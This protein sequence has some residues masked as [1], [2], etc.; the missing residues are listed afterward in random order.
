MI[1]ILEILIVG[2]VLS[3]DSFSAALAMGARKHKKSDVLKF[4]FSSG[5]AE[6]LVTFLGSIAGAKVIAEFDSVDHWISFFLLSIVAIHMAIE[7]VAE[8]KSHKKNDDEPKRFH[9]FIK[10]LIV[11]LAT[12]LDAFAVGVS[13]GVAGKPLVPFIFS[14]GLWAFFSTIIGMKVASKAS[15]KLGP[16]FSLIGSLVIITLAFKFLFEGL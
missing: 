14:I 8:F 12:S 9:S 13:L 7:G 15:S 3:A 6:A 10:I 11:S 1:N 5:G 2:L 4:A 16:I